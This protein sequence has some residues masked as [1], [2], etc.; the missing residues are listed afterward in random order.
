MTADTKAV[1]RFDPH[2]FKEMRWDVDGDYVLFT[3]HERVVAELQEHHQGYRE[4]ATEET[5]RLRAEVEGLR[6]YRAAFVWAIQK[7][8]YECTYQTDF[9]ELVA[10]IDAMEK[11]NA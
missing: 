7:T 2:N 3:D 8:A 10:K 5:L 11:R 6:K 9:I 1:T 4:A